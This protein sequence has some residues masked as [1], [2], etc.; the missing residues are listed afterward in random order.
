MYKVY[1]GFNFPFTSLIE[2]WRDV[3][4]FEGKL[5]IPLPKYRVGAEDVETEFLSPPSTQLSVLSVG[6]FE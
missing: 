1:S 3:K 4:D 2:V 5:G 6:L